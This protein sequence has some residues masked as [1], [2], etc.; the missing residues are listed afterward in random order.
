ML[1]ALTGRSVR[2][3]RNASDW[4]AWGEETVASP[5]LP[6]VTQTSA[7]Q[8]SVVYGSA[9]L[10]TDEVATL[11]VDIKGGP[12][13]MWIDEPA[14]GLDRVA[15]TGQIVWSLL[16][17]GN[18]YLLPLS[19]GN[20]I[21]SVEPL[22]PMRCDVRVERGARKV[23]V[24]GTVDA[25]VVHIPGRM[26]PGALKG[27][28]PIE[29]HRSVIGLGL[30]AAQYGA[31]FFANGEGNMP[32]VIEMAGAAQPET[33][34]SIA[35]QWRRKRRSGG[36]G[37]P[38]VLDNGAT[39]KA[40]GVTNEQAQFLATRKYTDAQIAAQVFLLDPSDL[41]IPVEGSSITYANQQQRDSRRLRIALMPWIRRIEPGVTRLLWSGGAYTFD[42]DSRLRGHTKE[43]YETLAIALAAGFMT[44]DEVRA[45]LGM[46]P[47]PN[48]TEAPT[49]RELAEMIQKIYLGVGVVLTADEAREILNSGGANL[50][51]GF[52]PSVGGTE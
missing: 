52:M 22:D 25:R 2:E 12:R 33:L 47:R 5:G 42:V 39:W 46:P 19:R 35:R 31:E 51:P 40:T 3:V 48:A 9:S 8:L 28:S 34:N 21:L 30:A 20:T 7:G 11:P 44:I 18:A 6:R 26:L 37:L 36:R 50:P 45:I 1:S 29:W 32:G 15:W 10:I 14:P 38:G 27:M 41:G 17:A 16:M 24:D 43:S 4:G 13:P 23:F 49:A